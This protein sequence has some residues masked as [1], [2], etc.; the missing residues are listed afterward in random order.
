MGIMR[1]SKF[2]LQEVCESILQGLNMITARMF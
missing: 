1:K 2:L